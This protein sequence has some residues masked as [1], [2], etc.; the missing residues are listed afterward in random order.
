V[1]TSVPTTV[2]PVPVRT[3]RRG[4][5]AGRVAPLSAPAF[6]VLVLAGNSLTE[7]VATA[8]GDAA[9]AALATFAAK[10]EDPLVALGIVMELTGFVL[11][12][13]FTA[14]LVDALR[15]RAAFGVAGALAVIGAVLM[16]AVKLGSAAP[17]LTGVLRHASL[18][19]ESALLLSELNG[20]GFVIGW[21]PW[22]LFV[23]A[24]AVALRRAG[25]LGRLGHVAGLGT[26]TLGVV[27]ALAGVVVPQNANPLP[28]LAGLLWLA[29]VGVRVTL[30]G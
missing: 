15:R 19:P 24:A 8:P 9:E 18:S 4:F 16:L 22:A 1:S 3:T 11:L 26:G 29:A 6:V 10:A 23:A 28:F 14:W 2:E 27:A 13:V 25:L 7:T 17:Y 20:A 5:T 12:A 30:R 21:L